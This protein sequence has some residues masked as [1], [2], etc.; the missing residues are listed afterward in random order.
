MGFHADGRLAI[1]I[2]DRELGKHAALAQQTGGLFVHWAFFAGQPVL[3]VVERIGLEENGAAVAEQ[4]RQR[5][6]R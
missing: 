6:L 4:V 3:M 2:R 1:L 5:G